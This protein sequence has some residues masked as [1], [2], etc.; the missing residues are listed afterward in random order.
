MNAD[1][2]NLDIAGHSIH[3]EISGK[4]EPILL[5]NGLGGDPKNLENIKSNLSDKQV[6]IY[7]PPGIGKSSDISWPLR[8]SGHARIAA[9]VIKSLNIN[10]VNAFGVSWGGAVVQELAYSAPDLV[11]KLI[12][13]ST[14]PGPI[15]WTSPSTLVNR[16]VK[17][18]IG[19]KADWMQIAA[20]AG[21]TSLPFLK[22]IQHSTLIISGTDD[23]LVLPY[24]AKLLK[25]Q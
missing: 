14:M 20:I 22:K 8:I 7:D 9:E 12:L 3:V 4:G 21:W 19:S 5:I 1:Q 23:D 2:F 11:K 15:L 24:N 10:A 18:I 25:I 16:Y 6:I 17:M 13:V